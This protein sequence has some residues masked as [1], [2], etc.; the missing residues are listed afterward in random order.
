MIS[1]TRCTEYSVHSLQNVYIQIHSY[2]IPQ[3]R[4]SVYAGFYYGFL[5]SP[6]TTEVQ[7]KKGY[8]KTPP[9]HLLHTDIVNAKQ[10]AGFAKGLSARYYSSFH[11]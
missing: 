6:L 4:P 8:V 1:A 5:L 2:Y 9:S 11:F 3:T 7:W 10:F